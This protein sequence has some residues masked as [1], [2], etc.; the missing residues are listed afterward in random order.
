MMANPVLQ[1]TVMQTSSAVVMGC[2]SRLCT[3]VTLDVSVRTVGTSSRVAQTVTS[4]PD[5]AAGSIQPA[6]T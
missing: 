6:L 5:C 1:I 2:V 3:T 4:S